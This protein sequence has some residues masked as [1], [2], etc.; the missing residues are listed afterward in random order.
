[1][2]VLHRVY[3]IPSFGWCGEYVRKG[4]KIAKR[5]T[6]DSEET[7]KLFDELLSTIPDLKLTEERADQLRATV[8]SQG[9]WI[10]F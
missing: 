1:M 8:E 2:K 5:V 4:F 6:A 7:L 10:A 3:F 9:G